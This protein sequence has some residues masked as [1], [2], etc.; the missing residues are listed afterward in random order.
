MGVSTSKKDGSRFPQGWKTAICKQGS[1]IAVLAFLLG[2]L[3]ACQPEVPEIPQQSP[4]SVKQE[5]TVSAE[6]VRKPGCELRNYEEGAKFVTEAW[7]VPDE[8]F[9]I[10]EPLRLQMRVSSPTYMN[11]FH[12]STSCKVTRLVYNKSMVEGEIVDFPAQDIQVTVKPPPGEEA[13]Y[14][15]ATRAELKVF[16]QADILR[17]EEIASLD[18]TPEEFFVRLDQASG[19]INPDDLSITTLRTTVVRH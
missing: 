4:V 10:G 1:V 18:L 3:S 17:G 9:N 5:P 12:V 19:R 16:A 11:V 15:V 13:F 6:P 14:F 8:K 2:L 7:A